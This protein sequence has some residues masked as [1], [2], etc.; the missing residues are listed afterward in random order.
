M[1]DEEEPDAAHQLALELLGVGL[2]RLGQDHAAEAEVLR[3]EHLLTHAADRQHLAD[4]R[5]L[6]G[7]RDVGRRGLVRQRRQERA[8]DRDAG[9]RA[10]LLDGARREVQVQVA[11]VEARDVDAELLG[12]AAQVAERQPRGLVHDV[13]EA[14][15][16]L[17]RTLAVAAHRL[18]VEHVAADRRPGEPLDHAGQ[19][20]LAALVAAEARA[21]QQPL[22]LGEAQPPG[23]LLVGRDQLGDLAAEPAHD[24]V[25]AAHAGLARVVGHDALPDR[26]RDREVLGL[27]AVALQLLGQ[28]VPAADL[29]LLLQQVAGDLEDLH[30]V[31]QRL[32][33]H[34]QHVRRRQEHHLR[35]VEGHV[36]VVVQERVV[37]L[38]VEHLQQRRARVPAEVAAQLVEL[39]EQDHRVVGPG[40]LEPL[41][42]PARQRA[43]VGAPV[44]LDLGLVAHPAER[45]P[46]ELPPHRA[47]DAA[48]EA[49][50]A[51][52]RRTAEAQDRAGVPGAQLAHR[53]ELEDALL[54]LLEAVVVVAQ[55][56]RG[57]GEV[58]VVLAGPR[59]GQR[60]QP[61]EVVADD[62]VLAALDRRGLHPRHLLVGAPARV[63]GH[64]RV[65]DRLLQPLQLER[66]RVL[67]LAELAPDDL[68]LLLE[69]V[70]LL[71]LLRLLT[72][73]VLDLLVQR[74]DL[75]L[76]HRELQGELE[77]RLDVGRLQQ[78]LAVLDL[79]HD[80]RGEV[81]ELPRVLDVEQGR[82]EAAV[83]LLLQLRQLLELG[84]EQTEHR[85]GA[86]S[87]R[88]DLDQLLDPHEQ[89]RPLA[90][91]L[92]APRAAHALGHGRLA[93]VGQ[94]ERLDDARD[95][96]DLVEV[97][98]RRG[99]LL[100]RVL[101]QHQEQV[102]VVGL[103]LGD[104][105]ARRRRV[106]QQRHHQARER[107][108]L[109]QREHEHRV[110]HR[111]LHDDGV[112]APLGL[113]HQRRPAGGLV[114]VA[115]L[116]HVVDVVAARRVGR[117]VTIL[118]AAVVHGSVVG[119][120]ALQKNAGAWIAT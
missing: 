66:A 100:V 25:E 85:L 56:A 95:D 69:E 105:V 74:R 118:G 37:L 32:R 35:Q 107:H 83:C 12:P 24:L 27:Q 120:R 6:A 53:Q 90:H 91:D 87:L 113:D 11:R 111:V 108:R 64:A 5:Q 50:L 98:D 59:P 77:P 57:A 119:A 76:G 10:V 96:A 92:D 43:D 80:A 36:Q 70:L 33:D 13:A 101:L 78:P 28:Q 93:A 7:H 117:V 19:R 114:A 86:F 60:G 63:V 88:G 112:P 22:H 3:G 75:V 8:R 97:V 46:E 71:R 18:D 4:D 68:Q 34:R 20:L 26:Q 52:A 48:P 102:A 16:Q 109:L 29:D 38:G 62:A 94:L 110:R 45:E 49:G 54:D 65:V 73:L 42:D 81:G 2:V 67:L 31:A 14:P 1:L 39:V 41:Q 89:V 47:R 106:E 104:H 99:V 15:G 103:G 44:S 21:A 9:R 115:L 58:G 23:R 116:D 82:G 55:H 30:P 72:D 17:Q 84:L 40:R 51:D 61:V 79:A